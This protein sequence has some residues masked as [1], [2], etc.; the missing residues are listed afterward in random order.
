VVA[1]RCVVVG[2]CVVADHSAAVD[3][4]AVVGLDAAAD[5][6]G[7]RVLQI[8][9]FHDVAL[10][11]IHAALN[12]ARSGVPNAVRKFSWGDF[13]S[14]ALDVAPVAARLVVQIA[15]Q[16]AILET[17]QASQ[18][19]RYAAHSVARDCYAA[20]G[21]LSPAGHAGVSPRLPASPAAHSDPADPAVLQAGL[22]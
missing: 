18:V 7:A 12:V 17:T 14:V 20:A 16:V 13:R 5:R 22:T 15:A 8:V 3:R 4:S 21:F 6:F 11:E 2:R 1:D 19:V 10:V 9:A